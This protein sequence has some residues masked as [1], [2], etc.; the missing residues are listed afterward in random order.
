METFG[1]GLNFEQG[2]RI[3]L[4]LVKTQSTRS[5][6]RGAAGKCLAIGSLRKIRPPNV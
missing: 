4:E 1:A 6:G 3:T 2:T 5:G